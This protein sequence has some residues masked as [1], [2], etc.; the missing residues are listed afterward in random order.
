MNIELPAIPAGVLILL[1]FFAP[2]AIA[3]INRPEWPAKI[4]K[5]VTVGVAV[6]L[7]GVVMLFYYAMT[8]EPLPSW[9][10]AIILT[11]SVASASYALVTK[12]SATALEKRTSPPPDD[13]GHAS[14]GHVLSAAA[15]AVAI[16]L[17][18]T[19]AMLFGARAVAQQPGCAYSGGGWICYG[20]QPPS[21]PG[22]FPVVE[23]PAPEPAPVEV[24]VTGPEQPAEP[25]PVEPAPEAPPT[26][27][28][29]P[30]PAPVAPEPV[31][32]APA[33][34]APAPAPVV[35]PSCG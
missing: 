32:P 20:T 15:V 33:P 7:T 6:L 26:S 35:S 28:P 16:M 2:Y 11:L 22:E 10:V 13:A 5:L 18:A 12:S 30:A 3:L 19:L 29:E 24:E 9:P 14:A 8:G 27:A 31:E 23:Q 25:A 17:I 4:K 1:G 34:P 21:E